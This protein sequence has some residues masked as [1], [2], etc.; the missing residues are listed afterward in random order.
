[1]SVGGNPTTPYIYEP[2]FYYVLPCGTVYNNDPLTWPNSHGGVTG[3]P[4]VTTFQ[5]DD[6]RQVVKIDY[7]GIG[8]K[9]YTQTGATNAVYL[10]NVPDAI[11]GTYPWQICMVSPTTKIDT[12]ADP[13]TP[14]ADT[15]YVPVA[16]LHGE[17]HDQDRH[18]GGS[19]H[20]ACGYHVCAGRRQGCVSGGAGHMDDQRGQGDAHD[21][22]VA[23]QRRRHVRITHH[24]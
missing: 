13:A 17:P 1:M 12:K 4:E 18:E 7:T 23:G 8:Y 20:T 24:V 10:N 2:I 3:D 22:T 15:T 16:D 14:P 21:R 19:R 6:G 5:A 9:Y 11:S